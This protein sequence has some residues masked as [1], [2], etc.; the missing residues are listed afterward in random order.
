MKSP[1]PQ[2][3]EL[4]K[5]KDVNKIKKYKFVKARIDSGMQREDKITLPP[6][7][8]YMPIQF[9]KLIT[10]INYC[11]CEEKYVWHTNQRKDSILCN[12][13]L[14]PKVDKVNQVYQENQLK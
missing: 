8:S 10:D 1:E 3:I 5:L 6:L 7:I 2:Q 4:K 12:V 11:D 13:C 9:D 14:K